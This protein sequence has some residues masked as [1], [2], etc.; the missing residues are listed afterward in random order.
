MRVGKNQ[1][2]RLYAIALTHLCKSL[3]YIGAGFH[4]TLVKSTG[5][6]LACKDLP[7]Y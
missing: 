6:R 7:L 3:I 5:C 4:L 2:D 1:R